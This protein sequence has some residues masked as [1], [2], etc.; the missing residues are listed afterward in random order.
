MS[1]RRLNRFVRNKFYAH[2]SIAWN[3]KK[4]SYFVISDYI[5]DKS[6]K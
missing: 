1:Y 4:I 2:N 6:E 3:L 5:F